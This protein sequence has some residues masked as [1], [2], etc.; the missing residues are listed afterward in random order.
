MSRHTQ[1]PALLTEALKHTFEARWGK[2]Q[3]GRGIPCTC[4]STQAVW[5]PWT[6]HAPVP[7]Q[8]DSVFSG[9]FQRSRARVEVRRRELYSHTLKKLSKRDQKG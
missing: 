3:K 2:V 9:T 6:H 7:R 8:L 5:L 4:W 1:S